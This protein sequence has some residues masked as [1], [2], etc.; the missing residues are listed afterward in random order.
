MKGFDCNVKLSYDKAVQ[1]RNSG[2]DFVIRYVGR[3]QQASFDIDK[4]EVDAILSAGLKLA[5]VQHC[6]VPGWVTTKDLGTLYGINAAKFSLGTGYKLGC[7]I[8]LDLE[9]I[10]QGTPKADIL[11]FCNAWYDEVV[12]AGYIPGIYIGYNIYL[13]GDELYNLLRFKHYWKSLSRVPEIPVRGYEMVQSAGGTINGVQIDNNV[14]TADK[15]GGS[16][17]FMEPEIK[18]LSWLDIIRKCTANPDNW[19]KAIDTAVK[20]AETDGNLGDLEILKY[21]PDLIKKIY[22]MKG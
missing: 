17:V 1:F 8:Y 21:L 14:S 6:P 11:A 15:L 10:K 2:F 3:T 7:I 19:Q 16:P 9:G 4:A 12:K 18:V 5:I 13:T 22:T 20:A